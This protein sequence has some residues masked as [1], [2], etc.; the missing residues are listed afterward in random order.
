MKVIDDDIVWLDAR[1]CECSVR[2]RL[3]CDC[4]P[5]IGLMK[6]RLPSWVECAFHHCEIMISVTLVYFSSG[7]DLHLK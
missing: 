7:L 1:V 4:V 6:G 3:Y 2:T 5:Q